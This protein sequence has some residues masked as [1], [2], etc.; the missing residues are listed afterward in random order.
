M[1]LRALSIGTLCVLF[2]CGFGYYNDRILELESF[3]NGH[4]LPILVIGVLVL[5]VMILNPL[6]RLINKRLPLRSAELAL[7]VTLSACASGIPGRALMEQFAQAI[8]MPYHWQRITPGWRDRD[9]LQYFP[10]GTL[11]EMDEQDEVLNRFLTGSDAPTTP[12]ESLAA[13]TKLKLKQVP[14]KYWRAPLKTWAP[15]IFFTMLAMA[16]MAL[17]VHKQWSSHEHLQYPIAEFTATLLE[18]ESG[19]AFNTV[20]QN[21]IFWIGF[22]LV[23]AMRINNG[24]CQWFPQELIPFKTYHSLWPFASKWPQLHR[25]PW[26]YGLMRIEIFPLVTAFAFFLSA[27]ISFTLGISQIIWAAFCI[28]VVGYGV[29]ISTDYDLGGWQAW[30]RAGSYTAYTLMLIYTGRFYYWNLL[31]QAFFLK[32]KKNLEESD[33]PGPGAV[34]SL[35]ILVISTI[36]LVLMTIRLGLSWPIALGTI[37]LMLITFLIVARISAETGLFFIQPGWQPAGTLAALFG[38][39]AIGPTALLIST[40]VCNILCI[41]Q[42]QALMPYLTNGLRL[43]DRTKTSTVK[44]TQATF[45]TY[46]VG[47]ILAVFVVIVATYDQGTPANY[48]WSFQRIP[49]NPIRAADPILMQLKATDTLEASEALTGIERIMNIKPSPAFLWAAGIGFFGVVIFSALRLRTRWWPIH[50]CMF[51][52]WA[53]Y[54]ITVMSHA[55]LGGWIIK[56][57]C[58]RFGGNKLV[59][60]LKPFAIGVISAE[61]VGALVFMIVG[62]IYYFVTGDK[63]KTY[64]YFPR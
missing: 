38:S 17:V 19:K 36:A 11:V 46:I 22:V 54:P 20:L 13:W 30:N 5:V 31:K 55:F 34:T 47:I 53:T 23:L 33:I 60:K 14:W 24:L 45:A 18:Q 1:S 63:P 59:Q 62:A 15:F 37:I 52:I 56:K 2:I 41:D 28:P 58:L 6:L 50:P 8:I 7:I 49:T 26:A 10:K 29:N 61:V 35:R 51:L 39:Y 12:P 3:N 4:Q 44:T 16:A 27:E 43:A 57:C 42:S 64:R 25:N 40:L 9:M 32:T 21:R 48:H